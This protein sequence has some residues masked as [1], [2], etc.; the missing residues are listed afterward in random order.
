MFGI[1]DMIIIAIVAGVGLEYYR[2]Y[3]KTRRRQR[4]ND[5]EL[6]RRMDE[7]ERSEEL[8]ALEER[9]RNL[10]AIVTDKKTRLNDEIDSL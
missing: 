4:G 5:D 8:Q 6:S 3:A 10:E 2:I 1:W 9:V 7:L